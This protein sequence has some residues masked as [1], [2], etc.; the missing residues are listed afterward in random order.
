MPYKDPEFRREYS[1]RQNKDWYRRN[2]EHHIA[3]VGNESSMS[4][5]GRCV[6]CGA[7]TIGSSKN[8]AA[9]QFC[10]KHRKEQWEEKLGKRSFKEPKHSEEQRQI[11]REAQARRRLKLK[12]EAIPDD[13]KSTKQ[14]SAERRQE[15][16]A[17]ATRKTQSFA[18][19]TRNEDHDRD[20]TNG[21]PP[22]RRRW[23]S[24]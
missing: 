4:M 6:V 12:G 16:L 11:W 14:S 17:A 2:R 7:Q 15:G 13:L 1:K 10:R 18:R 19:L 5:G 20:E 22:P 9:P 3:K 23:A 24:E 21:S 8:D